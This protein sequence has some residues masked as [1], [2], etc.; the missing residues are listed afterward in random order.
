MCPQGNGRGPSSWQ[1]SSPFDKTSREFPTLIH[2]RGCLGSLNPGASSPLCSQPSCPLS[3]PFSPFFFKTIMCVPL[4]PSPHC[5]CW[6]PNTLTPKATHRKPTMWDGRRDQLWLRL[7]S[8]NT[9]VEARCLLGDWWRLILQAV[10]LSWSL[11]PG[12][13]WC[14]LFPPPQP[15]TPG[16]DFRPFIYILQKKRPPCAEVPLIDR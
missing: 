5:I 2:S 12:W 16:A 8:G 14:L 4:A 7:T 9:Q 15:H 1:A 11:L 6:W 3:Y 13:K 10:I